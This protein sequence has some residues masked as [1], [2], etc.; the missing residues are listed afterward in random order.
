METLFEQ[1]LEHS[2]PTKAELVAKRA[3]RI[4]ALNPDLD[5]WDG[6]LGRDVAGIFVYAA[7]FFG[8]D[9]HP[10]RGEK[11]YLEPYYNNLEARI[12]E[13]Y[14]RA[15]ELYCLLR[16]SNQTLWQAVRTVFELMRV[17]ARLA[18]LHYYH[19]DPPDYRIVLTEEQL[20]EALSNESG[21]NG[22]LEMLSALNTD[23]QD[24]PLNLGKLLKGVF[25]RQDDL[26]CTVR[27]FDVSTEDLA[28]KIVH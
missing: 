11:V 15:R 22:Y 26:R 19:E 28:V 17:D 4:E 3:I 10:T 8:G 6:W 13:Y 21:L 20:E 2:F 5:D 9:L 25:R 27:L 16:D 23:K 12:L 1:A 18:V 24:T 7:E 14:Q